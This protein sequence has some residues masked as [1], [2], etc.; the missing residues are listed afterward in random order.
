MKQILIIFTL[1][2]SISVYGQDSNI[3][4]YKIADSLYQSENYIEALEIYRELE[5][6]VNNKDTLQA[7]VLW[8]Y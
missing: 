1:I 5:K 4:Q 6:T 7:Y 8:Y 2:F 3:E